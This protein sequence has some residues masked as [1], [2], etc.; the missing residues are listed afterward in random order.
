MLWHKNCNIVFFVNIAGLFTGQECRRF[1]ASTYEAV[2]MYRKYIAT[3][4]MGYYRLAP[5]G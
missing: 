3:K 2:L 5:L 1:E 4:Q